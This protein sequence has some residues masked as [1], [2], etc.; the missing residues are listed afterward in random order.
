VAQSAHVNG[1][2]VPAVRDTAIH[3]ACLGDGKILLQEAHARGAAELAHING[4]LVPRVRGSAIHVTRLRGERR[5][6]KPT[7]LLEGRDFDAN[8]LGFV[9]AEDWG[10]SVC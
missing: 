4:G 7:W 6:E 1:G 10:L 8:R 9:S 2:E 3:V 5:E